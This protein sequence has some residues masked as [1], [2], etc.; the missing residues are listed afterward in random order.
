MNGLIAVTALSVL[1]V[2]LTGCNFLAPKAC[3]TAGCASGL[4]VVLEG[5]PTD[6]FTVTATDGAASESISCE[7]ATE[8]DL[9]FEGFTPQQVTISY[10]S[11]GHLVEETFSPGYEQSRPNGED[12]P[13]VCLN[14]VV[15]LGLSR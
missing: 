4:R 13:P 9:F 2:G 6:P 11:D 3:T 5:T 14:G 12:C 15:V 8:C 1:Y 7:Q 10:Q